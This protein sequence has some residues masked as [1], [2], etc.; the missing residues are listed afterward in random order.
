M[1]VTNLI[2]IL[3]LVLGR[4]SEGNT[5]TSEILSANHNGKDQQEAQR[6]RDEHPGE[7]ECIA[8]DRVCSVIAVTR[9]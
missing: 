8:N 4:K 1:D 6:V 3:L 2:N 5:W 9:G 7:E